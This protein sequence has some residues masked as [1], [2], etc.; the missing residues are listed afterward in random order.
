LQAWIEVGRRVLEGVELPRDRRLAAGDVGSCLVELERM[1]GRVGRGL[2]REG[3][4]R[5]GD[6]PK[7]L[8]LLERRREVDTDVAEVAGDAGTLASD[9]P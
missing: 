5:S 8:V 2:V 6:L 4:L 7:L 9:E 1:C 3:S